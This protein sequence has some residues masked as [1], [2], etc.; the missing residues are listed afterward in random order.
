VGALGTRLWGVGVRVAALVLVLVVCLLAFRWREEVRRIRGRDQLS[1]IGLAM[2]AYLC[3]HGGNTFYPPDL[4]VLVDVGLLAAG[5]LV[6]SC[7][8][9]PPR[10]PNGLRC[11]YQYLVRPG[12][13]GGIPSN[14]PLV[15]ERRVFTG[16]GLHVLFGDSHVEFW[17]HTQQE[18]EGGKK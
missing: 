18:P 2:G 9:D 3:Q 14:E 7:D 16:E 12:T 17:T 1:R 8:A 6:H 15:Q 5:D 13:M 10:L 11:S 4:G